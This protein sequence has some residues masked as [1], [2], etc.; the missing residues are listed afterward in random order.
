VR[1]EAA[2]LV[3]E[4]EELDD[5]VS[6]WREKDTV[7]AGGSLVERGGG[8]TKRDEEMGVGDTVARGGCSLWKVARLL[9]NVGAGARRRLYRSLTVGL[10]DDFDCVGRGAGKGLGELDGVLARGRGCYHARHFYFGFF[11][12]ALDLRNGKRSE[13]LQLNGFAMKA[14]AVNVCVVYE[15][16]ARV[17]KATSVFV[18]GAISL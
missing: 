10:A 3:D 9:L 4:R 6:G 1:R 18:R 2:E 5:V 15:K 7:S 14:E 13:V 17:Y 12:S 16:V 11:R 8:W